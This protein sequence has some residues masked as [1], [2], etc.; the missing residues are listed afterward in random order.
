VRERTFYPRGHREK[1]TPAGPRLHISNL[2]LPGLRPD[3]HGH[4]PLSANSIAGGRYGLRLLSDFTLQTSHLKP[5]GP[6][7]PSSHFKLETWPPPATRLLNHQSKG[8][9]ASY[10]SRTPLHAPRGINREIR[11]IREERINSRRDAKNGGNRP[12]A[13]RLLNH[14]SKGLRKKDRTHPRPPV[15]VLRK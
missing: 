10:A 12:P 15:M 13:A 6:G 9:R 1:A 7:P 5:A 2:T 4:F 3:S 11:Q 8:L 14:Q